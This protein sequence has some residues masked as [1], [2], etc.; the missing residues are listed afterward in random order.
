LAISEGYAYSNLD[1][2]TNHC[3]SMLIQIQMQMFCYKTCVSN[4]P[5]WNT[6]VNPSNL[7]NIGV[8]SYE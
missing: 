6:V 7:A 2:H 5:I 4:D 8:D 3:T 1:A